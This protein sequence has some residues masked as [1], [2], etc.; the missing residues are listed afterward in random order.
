MVG[1][2]EEETARLSEMAKHARTFMLQ[3]EWCETIRALYFG[4]G[5]GEV[6][7]IFLAQIKPTKPNIDEYL[8]VVVG[9]LPPAYLV[10]DDSPTPKDALE[11]Y[12][13]E[14]R[15]WVAAAKSGRSLRDVIPVDVPAT[16]EWAGQL[17]GRL[18]TLEN[19]ILPQW[20]AK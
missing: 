6:F 17:E 19:E 5:I 3:F 7:G 14:M 9:D 4:D 15:R 10:T 13:E 8:W 20:F 18:D 1:E 16:P 2:D 12:I 11:A